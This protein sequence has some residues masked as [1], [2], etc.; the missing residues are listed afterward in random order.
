[1]SNG[2]GEKPAPAPAPSADN[3]SWGR[4][5]FVFV[6]FF[7][8]SGF[9]AYHSHRR[10]AYSQQSLYWPSVQGLVVSHGVQESRGGKSPPGHQEVVGYTYVVDGQ[11][12]SSDVVFWQQAMVY[13]DDLSAEKAMEND[14]P[15]RSPVPVY[16][17][18]D[19]PSV[20][21]LDRGELG[22]TMQI[23]QGMTGIFMVTSGGMIG[24]L[25]IGPGQTRRRPAAT[26]S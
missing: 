18:P 23:S 25:L 15:I 13:P 1:M 22:Y 17:D 26:Q 7:L 2:G 14:Y 11:P 10:S 5:L 6:V 4:Y 12:Y 16:Y 19:N 8:V 9:F 24:L 21:C 20:S 3:R